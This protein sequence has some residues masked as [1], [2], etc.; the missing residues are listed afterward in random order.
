MNLAWNQ[1]ERNRKYYLDPGSPIR[2]VTKVLS[3]LNLL[4]IG[5][6]LPLQVAFLLPLS[7]PWLL[8]ELLSLSL[9]LLELIVKFRTIVFIDSQPSL[10]FKEILSNYWHYNYLLIDAMAILPLNLILAPRTTEFEVNH[11]AS[12]ARLVRLVAIWK[13]LPL[14]ERLEIVFRKFELVVQVCRP[15]FFLIFLWMLTA[16]FWFYVTFTVS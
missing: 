14:F 9:S 7:T 12:L 1:Y 16:C 6:S 11:L 5:F 3:A 2:T 13:M 15:L 10:K 8:L 4:F